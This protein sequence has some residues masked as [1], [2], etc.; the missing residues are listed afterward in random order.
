MLGSLPL[1]T[2]DSRSSV[3]SF[4]VSPASS[5]AGAFGLASSLCRLSPDATLGKDGNKSGCFGNGCSLPV[6][7]DDSGTAHEK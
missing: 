6:S 1:Y 7:Y 5:C 4:S 3:S 2:N